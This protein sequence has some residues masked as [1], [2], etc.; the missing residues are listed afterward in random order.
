MTEPKRN[1]IISRWRAGSS[2]RKIARELGLARNTVSRVLE[3]IEAQR[4]SHER[5][6][7]RRR[8]SRLDP[9]LPLI[10]ELLGRYPDLTA[11]RLLEELR[12]RGF[13]GGYSVV[14]QRLGV[15]RPRSTPHPVVR[16]ETAP[17]A[18]AQMDYAVYD[19]DFTSE[20][21]RRVNLFSYI[22]GH[23]RR[24]YLRFVEAQDMTTTLREH[25]R[26][27]EHLGGVAA[28]CLY[29]N[30]KVVVTGYED[31]VPVYNS[32]FLAFAT[33][34]GFRPV[35]CRPRRPQTKGKV[36]RPFSYVE[37]SLFNGRTFSSLD[38]LNQVTVW[39][40][41]HVADVRQ[42][43]EASKTPLQLHA[44]EQPHLIP[45]PEEPYDVSPVVYRTVNV[46]ALVTYCQN[47][48]S[49]PWRYIGS[50]L[51]VRITEKELIVYG[52]EVEEIARHVLLP[53][54]VT[55]QR[56]MHKE[57]RPVEDLGRRQAQLEE[58]F[59]ELGEPGR[60][61]LE[62]L[63][64]VQ[65]YG[66]DQAQRVLALLGTYAQADLIAALQR[67]LR[68]GA[69]SH[70][71]VERILSAQARPRTILEALAQEERQQIPPWL[72]EDLVSPRPT[73]VY[74]YL[75]ESEPHDEKNPPTASGDASSDGAAPA[76]H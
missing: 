29:D 18:Q 35:A 50:M 23:S 59:A 46:E 42:L 24:Q 48:Y 66:K 8:P 22:L 37:T 19:L 6:P 67:A 13:T 71:A 62:G 10:Q 33:H 70:A 34:Y 44:D 40:L 58:R 30:M 64:Q 53:A 43:R 14:R 16:F 26:A 65:R 55:G 1:E 56:V 60:R 36:E 12:E 61:F 11:L 3:E 38:H 20:G 2:I 54:N 15:L 9:F 25:L 28:T 32:R 72:G 17:G 69:Y 63:F 31:D 45:L 68:Y 52:H 5:S 27:F 51:P 57:H 73:S 39:W 21:R 76:D 74:Q 49:V 41:A 7:I 75:C 47:G 4:T